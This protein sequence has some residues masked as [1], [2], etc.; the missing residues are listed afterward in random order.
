[1]KIQNSGQGEFKMQALYVAWLLLLVTK[2]NNDAA[3]EHQWGQRTDF[4][5]ITKEEV[6]SA[7]LKLNN[8]PMKKFNFQSPDTTIL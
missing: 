3:G 7:E 8:R 4:N 6:K 1:M 5:F 2:A